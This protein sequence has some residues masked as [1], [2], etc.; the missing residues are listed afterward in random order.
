MPQQKIKT[1]LCACLVFQ[2]ISLKQ[3]T[4][5]KG[6]T[7]CHLPSS[8]NNPLTASQ[9]LQA[10]RFT[11]RLSTVPSMKQYEL[12]FYSRTRHHHVLPCD[13]LNSTSLFLRFNPAFSVLSCAVPSHHCSLMAKTHQRPVAGTRQRCVSVR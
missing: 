13:A 9:S 4:V 10:H 6:F 5:T 11:G 8:E 2:T 7:G 1:A 3:H 12:C